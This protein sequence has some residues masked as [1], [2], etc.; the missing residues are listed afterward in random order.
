MLQ[1][2]QPEILP[3]TASIYS[4]DTHYPNYRNSVLSDKAAGAA[5]LYRSS[6]QWMTAA[7]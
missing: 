3:K 2:Y 6:Y 4:L 5:H 7:E 1:I